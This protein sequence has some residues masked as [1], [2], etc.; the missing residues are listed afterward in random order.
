MIPKEKEDVIFASNRDLIWPNKIE[1]DENNLYS[2]DV[3]ERERGN[4]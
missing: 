4:E 2:E 1:L 3:P